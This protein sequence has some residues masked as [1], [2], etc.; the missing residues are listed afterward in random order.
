MVPS[1]HSQFHTSSSLSMAKH[2][3]WTKVASF[4]SDDLIFVSGALVALLTVW[5]LSSF[6]NPNLISGFPENETKASI[7]SKK[8][9]CA[10]GAHGVNL[11]N[12]PDDLTFYDDPELSYSIGGQEIESWDEK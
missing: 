5:A 4:L 7:S 2:E 8:R 6:I 10:G 3:A 12:D 11:R 9:D 1:K